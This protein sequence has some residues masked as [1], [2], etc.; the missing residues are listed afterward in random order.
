[1]TSL[2][3][4]E[5]KNN[6]KK[7]CAACDIPSDAELCLFTG[8]LIDYNTTIQ[9]G[10]RESFAMQVDNNLYVYLDPPAR[11]F[12]HC[13]E[14]NCGVRPDLMLVSLQDIKKGEELRWDYSTSMLE[15]HWTMVCSCN[16]PTC[17]KVIRDFD[18]LPKALQQK[19]IAMN[20]VQKFIV[21]QVSI[22]V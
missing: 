5:E 7:V 15:H 20:I 12:N 21:K 22:S 3:R 4:V 17:R 8:K 19:Y 11:Y 1:M 14:P 6:E 9:L 13:C 16:K 10:S 2:F 18:T